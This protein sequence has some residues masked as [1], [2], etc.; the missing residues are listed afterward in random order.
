MK[1]NKPVFRPLS[2]DEHDIRMTL[3]SFILFC[4]DDSLIDYDGFGEFAT[5]TQ[6]SDRSINPSQAVA[7]VR[8]QIPLW[9]THVVWYNR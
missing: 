9:A 5:E 3:T 2:E 7:L 6:V 8:S 4:M 1:R